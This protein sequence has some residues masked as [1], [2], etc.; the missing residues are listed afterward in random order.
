MTDIIPIDKIENKIIVVRGQ[1]VILD[2]DLAEL[3]GVET[4]VL[5]QAVKRNMK[6]FPEDFMFQLNYKEF[7][8]L[9]S[10]FVTSSW[11][12]TRKMPY[13][14]TENGVAMLS[15]V[16]N[17]EKAIEINIQIMRVFNR[18][19]RMYFAYDE[20]KKMILELEQRQRD[21]KRA[22]SDEIKELSQILFLEVNRLEKLMKPRKQIGFKP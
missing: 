12:G 20:L 7:T 5:I 14:F 8:D 21:D 3:Y 19:K 18:F 2:R 13:A 11:G 9:I 17:S 16:L 15:S 10:Q 1:S 22:L 4:R 6:R